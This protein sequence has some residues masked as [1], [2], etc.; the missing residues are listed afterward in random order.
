MTYNQFVV[1]G[2]GGAQTLLTKPIKIVSMT[3]LFD[4]TNS[5]IL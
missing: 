4:F 5:N 3:F 2:A 1:D